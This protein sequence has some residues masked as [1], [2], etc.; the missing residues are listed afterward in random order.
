MR[1]PW[2]NGGYC[3]KNKQTNVLIVRI[4]TLDMSAIMQKWQVNPKREHFK[5]TLQFLKG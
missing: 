4:M 5:T 3:A 2:P 1:R